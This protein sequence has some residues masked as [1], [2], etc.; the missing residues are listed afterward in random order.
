MT[1]P[2]STAP[3]FSHYTQ[4]AALRKMVR[5]P[6]VGLGDVLGYAR[7]LA[8][9]GMAQAGREFL[10]GLDIGM[11]DWAKQREDVLAALATAPGGAVPWTSRRRRF[12][13]N[14]EIVARRWPEWTQ[15]IPDG[16][17]LAA[18]YRLYQDKA[19]NYQ[20]RDMTEKNLAAGWL[21]E[22][23]DHKSLMKLWE[24]T[25]TPESGQVLAPVGFDGAGYGWLLTH[26]LA[27]T[28]SLYLNY[29]CA[30]YMVEP[31]PV[32]LAMLLH[33]HDLRPWLEQPRFRLFLGPDAGAKFDASL[34]NRHWSIPNYVFA[35]PLT[36]RPPLEILSMTRAH[37]ARREQERLELQRQS[38][39]Y[40]ADKDAAY[41]RKR[42]DEAVSGRGE[43]LRVLGITSR[44]STVLKYSMMELAE[45]VRAVGHEFELSIESDDQSLER[46]DAGAVARFKP[47]LVVQISRLRNPTGDVPRK[48]PFLCWD[49]DNL[50]VMREEGVKDKLDAYT[51]VAGYG[52]HEGYHS[53]GWPAEN[54]IFCHLAGAT[55]RYHAGRVGGVGGD[56]ESDFSYVSN[57]AVSP[58]G[59][60]TAL[61][62]KWEPLG[63]E[64]IM[65]QTGR[66]L[67][68]SGDLFASPEKLLGQIRE[69][70]RDQSLRM[71]ALAEGEI[72][73]ELTRLADRMFRHEALRWVAQY[74]RDKGKSLRLYG[75]GWA[76]NAEFREFARGPIEPGEPMRALYQQTRI[77]LQLIHAGF[78]HS[79][80]LDGLAAGGFFLTRMSPADQ[81]SDAQTRDYFH[82]A[83]RFLE[84]G[85][86]SWADVADSADPLVRQ[87]VERMGLARV[88][89]VPPYRE[90]DHVNQMY[91]VSQIPS[92]GVFFEDLPTISFGSRDEF[93]RL[94]ERFLGDGACR[95]A[96]A[97]KMGRVVETEFSY[98]A[99]VR[100]FLTSLRRG[101]AAYERKGGR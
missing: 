14:M 15:M 40:Y 10:E 22:I 18:R 39:A 85:Y 86:G 63:G 73:V 28:E 42:Y 87:L 12:M 74:C 55:H 54:C 17:A 19:G 67:L 34:D 23:A 92:A 56:Y 99:R 88:P 70:A 72:G 60:L 46:D 36:D 8:N 38:E 76:E 65:R 96:M 45:A 94:A 48:A 43:R 31:D 98:D 9:L 2:A 64:G 80:S 7:A 3:L 50:P 21:N 6:R 4:L 75:Q 57:A 58:E 24:T 47:D 30:I 79:R 33:L 69:A 91:V 81:A 1:N 53:A 5:G 13:A 16:E 93:V 29:S 61:V 52:A 20:I 62:K 27:A 59:F 89:N 32:A 37:A 11:P 25:V 78:L 82:L 83:R 84:L 44:F 71:T 68:E 90:W 100:W 97:K 95:Q 77:N 41:W 49:Q 66:W 35:N 51:Y 26:V 101:F